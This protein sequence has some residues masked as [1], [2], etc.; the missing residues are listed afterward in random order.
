LRELRG[1]AAERL[2]ARLTESDATPADLRELHERLKMIDALL[3]ERP[4]FNARRAWRT[5]WPVALVALVLLVAASVPVRRVPVVLDLQ[6]SAV[7]VQFA[8]ASLL[9]PQVQAVG[10]GLRIEGFS[11]LESPDS[12]L[13]GAVQKAGADRLV[14]AGGD[15][16]LRSIG[17]PSGAMFALQRD[18]AGTALHVESPR[19]PVV[20]EV[21]MHG[22]TRV[23]VADAPGVLTRNYSHGEWVRFS[24]G[25]ATSVERAAPP[26]LLAQ[27][28]G[29]AAEALRWNGL[30]PV[31][32]RFTER[33]AAGSA[34]SAVGSSLLS[35][36]ITL[37][38]SAQKVTL[39]VGDGLEVDG[40]VVERFELVAGAP[41]RLTLTGSAHT[42]RTR[43]SDFERSLKPSWLEYVARHHLIGALWGAAAVLWGALAWIRKQIAAA[44]A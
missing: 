4:Q 31:A 24:A 23:Q 42:I 36:V 14:L 25:D 29:A 41:I 20:V 34:V 10:G 44:R 8:G 37:P 19:S 22:P 33:Q 21:E 9:E 6:A 15:L 11:A 1:A 26:L 35:G 43:V 28:P 18:G 39:S 16:R 2:A 32:L 40:L 3:A 38:A 7:G 17:L 27:Q 13:V 12:A 5:L 30:K